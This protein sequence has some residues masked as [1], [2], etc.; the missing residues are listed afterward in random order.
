[1]R[2]AFRLGVGLVLSLSSTSVAFALPTQKSSQPIEFFRGVGDNG[3]HY[4]QTTD[5]TSATR[6]APG[7]ARAPAPAPIAKQTS[8]PI[9]FFRGV[10]DNGSHYGAAN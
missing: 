2:N 9:E 1:M 8:Q 10:G 4:G 7:Q 6:A 3:S 5:T